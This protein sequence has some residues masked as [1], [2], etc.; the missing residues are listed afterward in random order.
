MNTTKVI[1]T[2]NRVYE[3]DSAARDANVIGP[4]LLR[5]PDGQFGLAVGNVINGTWTF[6][7]ATSLKT[8]YEE[9]LLR[10]VPLP[11][12]QVPDTPG[13]P[14]LYSPEERLHLDNPYTKDFHSVIAPRSA[15]RIV[16]GSKVA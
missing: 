2:T 3:T 16:N 13:I 7:W 8:P 15:D 9:R 10:A 14:V 12:D 5:L 1:L 4:F 6:E 11:V